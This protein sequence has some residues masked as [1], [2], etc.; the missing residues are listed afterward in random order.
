MA[1][2]FVCGLGVRLS[3]HMGSTLE[4]QAQGFHWGLVGR[5]PRPGMHGDFRS[6]KEACVS[7]H[8]VAHARGPLSA[9]WGAFPKSKLP[10]TR[11]Q[12]GLPFDPFPH[13]KPP[14]GLGQGSWGEG[15]LWMD[16]GMREMAVEIL[17]TGQGLSR[18][19]QSHGRWAT[20]TLLCRQLE[21]RRSSGPRV[22][23]QGEA[24]KEPRRVGGE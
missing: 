23:M 13:R 5:A 12:S 8:H 18:C 6:Q 7:R 14:Q 15:S 2:V 1:V 4:N 20:G 24:G 9:E 22:Q 16:V 21:D 19:P 3:G 11:W 10:D 17:C